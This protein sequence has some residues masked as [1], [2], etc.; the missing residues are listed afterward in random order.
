MRWSFNLG[1]ILG[2]PIRVH[3]TFLILLALLFFSDAME[4]GARSG[5]KSLVFMVLLFACVL[6]HE[7]GHS[8]VAMRFG[9]PINSITLYPFGGIAA[10]SEIPREPAREILIAVAGPLVNFAIAAGLFVTAVFLM[11][12]RHLILASLTGA[13]L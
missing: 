13:D 2:I 3:V 1:R 10:L 4:S 11:P 7:L 9:V 6:L 12:A 5:V 8:V